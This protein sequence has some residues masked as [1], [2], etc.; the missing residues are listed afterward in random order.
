MAII[1]SD[2]NAIDYHYI[3]NFKL[4]KEFIVTHDLNEFE[5]SSESIKISITRGRTFGAIVNFSVNQEDI[6]IDYINKLSNLST[7]VF[8]FDGELHEFHWDIWNQCHH[9]NVYWVISGMVNDDP[10]QSNIITWPY[11]FQSLMFLYN[12]NLNVKL[13]ELTYT[14]KP[15]MFDALLGRPRKH[16]TFIYNAIKENQL[17]DKFILSYQLSDAG[18]DFKK[19]WDDFIWEEGFSN[20]EEE[21]IQGTHHYLKYNNVNAA[22]SHIIPIQIYNES[23]YSIVAE[24]GYKNSYTFFTEKTAKPLIAKRLFVMFSGYKFLENLRSLGFQTFSD[25]IDESYDTIED[26]ESRWSAAFEQVK[27]LCGADQQTIYN[28]ISHILEHNHNHILKTNWH[29]YACN[30]IQNKI[31]LLK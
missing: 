2:D 10:I 16:R 24:T 26:D 23:A 9:D 3:K 7:I 25:V 19:Y 27:F 6:F 21:K 14:I 11:F 29:D 15:K 22:I 31:N 13:A 8:T 12:N 1:F 20:I 30:K 17:D 28:K 4:N 5:N 18:N